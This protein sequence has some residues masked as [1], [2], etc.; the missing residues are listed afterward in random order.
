MYLT[1]LTSKGGIS[2]NVRPLRDRILVKR[3]EEEEQRVG[4]IIIPD[5]AKEKP[6]QGKGVAAGTG[7]LTDEGKILPLDVKA[8]DRILFGK[9][10][11]TEIKLDG[12]EYLIVRE[13]EVLGIL[14]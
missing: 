6:Q 7:R 10:S 9:Y 12:E 13:D 3:L 2:M 8:G 14:D 5:T 1:L 11:G 4:G